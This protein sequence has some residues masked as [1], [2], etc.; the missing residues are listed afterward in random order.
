MHFLSLQDP[1]PNFCLPW[2][3]FDDFLKPS[4]SSCAPWRVG[5]TQVDCYSPQ[6]N[7][8]N[9]AFIEH[10]LSAQHCAVS[11]HKREIKDYSLPFMHVPRQDHTW[12]SYSTL[13]K[14]YVIRREGRLWSEL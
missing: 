1:V 6:G 7:A 11:V 8:V 2:Q 3:C 4:N 9:K 14:E 12:N 13:Q 5:L 10:L